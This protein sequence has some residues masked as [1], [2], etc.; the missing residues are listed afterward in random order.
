MNEY[1]FG[2]MTCIDMLSETSQATWALT[3]HG[4][5]ARGGVYRTL[6]KVKFDEGPQLRAGKLV[7]VEAR[8]SV[9]G[10]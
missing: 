3:V 2:C 6:E 10:R 1:K 5:L 8:P 7:K 4:C 9:L